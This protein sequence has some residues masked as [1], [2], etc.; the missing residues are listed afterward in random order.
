MEI[1]DWINLAAQ[2]ADATNFNW[3]FLLVASAAVILGS[4]MVNQAAAKSRRFLGF[5]LILGWLVFGASNLRALSNLVAQREFICAK[6]TGNDLSEL[7]EAL[8]PPGSGIATGLQIAVVVVVA[9]V[10]IRIMTLPQ[11]STGD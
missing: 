3:Y 6:I 1:K 2:R 9:G 5:S 4:Y 11:R 10:A 7:V 8:Q